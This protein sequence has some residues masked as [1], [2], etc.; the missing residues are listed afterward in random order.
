MMRPRDLH[1]GAGPELN[2]DC[3]VMGDRAGRA[4][5]R[6]QD[7]LGRG[8]AS[9]EERHRHAQCRDERGG[10]RRDQASTDSLPVNAHKCSLWC[11]SGRGQGNLD[12]HFGANNRWPLDMS[13]EGRS[14]LAAT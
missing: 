8:L 6:L 3:V 1:G 4:V 2:A 13:P 5:L 9:V 7:G 14:D 10:E 11:R 12:G